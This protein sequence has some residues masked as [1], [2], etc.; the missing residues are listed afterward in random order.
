MSRLFQGSFLIK[1]NSILVV[2]ALI[3]ISIIVMHGCARQGSPAGGPKDELPPQILS[4]SPPNRTV[5]FA[6][7]QATITFSEFVQLK[8]P[9]KEI[10]ISPPVRT[11]PEFKVQGK[12]LI[13][14]FQEALRENATYTI[15]FGSSIVD[16]TE[17]N[18]IVNYEYVFSTGDHIDSLFIPGQILNAIDHKPEVNIIAMVYQDN[19]DTIPL[20]SLPLKVPPINASRTIKDG[21]FR[22]NNLPEGEYKLFAL[23]DLNNN[24]IFDIPNERIAFLDSLITVRPEEIVSDTVVTGDSTDMPVPAFSVV[25]EELYTLYLFTEIDT[26]QKLLSKKLIGS[27][28]LQYIFRSPVDSTGIFPVGFDPGIPDWYIKEY[29]T[30]KDTLN[31]WLKTG[32]PDTIRVAL[33]AGDSLVDTTRFILSRSATDKPLRKK[34]TVAPGLK[35]TSNSFAGAFDLNKELTLFFPMPVVDFNPAKLHLYTLTDT[36]IPVFSFQDT[37][38]RTGKIEHQWLPEGFYHLM[39]EDSAFCDISGSYNDSTSVKFKVRRP[40]DY[41][42][43][44]INVTLPGSGGQFIIQLL[45]EKEAILEQKIVSNAGIIRF[46]YLKPGNYRLKAISDINRNKKWDKGNYRKNIL[47]EKIQYYEP[48]LN[49]KA[50]WDLQEEWKL[51]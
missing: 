9:A 47:P 42:I 22:I 17:S 8:D 2:F 14:E 49:I 51:E 48:P 24:Y 31:I 50:N 26:T 1:I 46:E 15:N 18:P 20:D 4:E 37:L 10:F 5:H 35:F 30:L 41:G 43:L 38:K 32:L 25:T 21:S 28:L 40:E 7:K 27:H 23:E 13:I 6:A 34:E 16:F 39:I 12:K 36:I 44:L 33:H 45:S 29:G 19:N 3:I 11:R